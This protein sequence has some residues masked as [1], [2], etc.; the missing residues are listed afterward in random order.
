MPNDEPIRLVPIRAQTWATSLVVGAG[1][2]GGVLQSPAALAIRRLRHLRNAFIDEP[3]LFPASIQRLTLRERLDSESTLWK[4]IAGGAIY[5]ATPFNIT[6]SKAL[7]ERLQTALE[8]RLSQLSWPVPAQ[9]PKPV[10]RKSMQL[11]L[12]HLRDEVLRQID[13]TSDLLQQIAETRTGTFINARL[14]RDADPDIARH[15]DTE[16]VRLRGQVMADE[17]SKVAQLEYRIIFTGTMKAGKTTVINAIVG[18]DLLPTRSEAMTTLPTLIKNSPGYGEPVL[19][20]RRAME[21]NMFLERLLQLDAEAVATLAPGV[22][23]SFDEIQNG[24]RFDVVPSIGAVSIRN[25]LT[26][27][28]DSLRIAERCGLGDEMM[29]IFAESSEDLPV[30]EVSFSTLSGLTKDEDHGR[31]V[32]IDSPGPNE[33][34]LAGR[35]RE[36]V[37]AQLDR[38]SAIVVVTNYT[39]Q[40]ALDDAEMKLIVKDYLEQTETSK[41]IVLVNKYDQAQSSDPQLDQIRMDL[42]VKYPSIAQNNI[43]AVSARKAALASFVHNDLRTLGLVLNEDRRA[44]FANE[45]FG[46]DYDKDNPEHA[47]SRWMDKAPKVWKRSYFDTIPKKS[48]PPQEPAD[49]E[50]TFTSRIRA[51]ADSAAQNCLTAALRTLTNQNRNIAAFLGVR[52]KLN[53]DEME[54]LK[55]EIVK[56]DRDIAA[57]EATRA[58]VTDK[59][60]G[61]LTEVQTTLEKESERWSHHVDRQIER[62]F[63]LATQPVEADD[64]SEGWGTQ[65]IAWWNRFSGQESPEVERRRSKSRKLPVMEGSADIKAD[66][67]GFLKFESEAAAQAFQERVN[68]SINAFSGKVVNAVGERLEDLVVGVKLSIT[69]LVQEEMGAT[70]EN[71]KERLGKEFGGEMGSSPLHLAGVEA[72][73]MR[74]NRVARQEQFSESVTVFVERETIGGDVQ[75]LARAGVNWLFGTGTV[76]WG[77]Q[78]QS[79]TI[80]STLVNKAELKDVH[81]TALRE[82]QELLN[83]TVHE[84]LSTTVSADVFAYFDLAVEYIERYKNAISDTLGDFA[85]SVEERAVLRDKVLA[86]NEIVVQ[87]LLDVRDAETAVTAFQGVSA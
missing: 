53:D 24:T 18:I 1:Q 73:G 30:I 31:L 20:L 87:L 35:L 72:S 19:R 69:T 75:R 59:L 79:R 43:F 34:T 17:R 4:R 12:Y 41:N 65:I 54:L 36:I 84:H 74:R 37:T 55:D 10:R 3:F 25:T 29:T 11:T 23:A 77:G 2:Q 5:L 13:L 6:E 7:L 51:A 64:H 38:C 68:A 85:L 52:S 22:R 60:A 67:D 27:L 26:L 16:Q 62:F 82:F 71:A 39:I 28:N 63:G 58:R 50:A 40:G 57:I 44:D 81:I 56:L 21:L 46:D 47:V 14:L 76:E 42:G 80:R 66:T 48:R 70:F 8:Y 33:A 49:G 86:L 45:A 15:L 78:W 83:K 9:P 61:V 32:L